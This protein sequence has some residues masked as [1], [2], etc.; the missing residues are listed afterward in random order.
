TR[1][2]ISTNYFFKSRKRKIKEAL[3]NNDTAG[4]AKRIK[5]Y[6]EKQTNVS[7]NIAI[8]GESGAGKSTFIN[9]FRGIKNR[10][11]GAAP[12]GVT[13]T[14]SEVTPYPHPDNPNVTLW[15]LPG[16]GT[17]DFPARKYLKLVGFDKYDFFLIISDTRFRENDVKLAQKIK[18]MKKNFYFVRSKI[19]ND[20]RAEESVSDSSKEKTLTKIRD[21][22]VQHL[23][24]ESPRVFLMSS[25]QLHKYDFS[26]LQETLETELPKDKRDTLLYVMPNVNPDV[27]S[28]KKKALKVHLYLLATLSAAAAA[29]PVP[30]LSVAVDVAVLIGAVT[31]FVH[32]FGLDVQSL[33]RLAI[34]TA[35]SYTELRDVIISPVAAKEI[36][37][38]L[39][40]KV[41]IPIV[42]IPVA[43]SL[44]FVT[45]YRVL[46][47]ILNQLAEDAQKVLNKALELS[48]VSE[49]ERTW[50]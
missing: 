19:D 6:L 45:T 10:D 49:P 32:A 40:L 42:G 41:F 15:D 33:K 48:T 2:R 25:F 47:F 36:T 18:K 26:L 17:K 13:E 3:K 23:G 16:I 11:E 27:I 20:I 1:M 29:V 7:L 37:K 22:C 14:T 31:H 12:T 50:L 28:K 46:N 44:S 5:E 34:R 38:E 8:T 35:V 4:A 24:I 39:F 30:G 9:A 21:D 43:M